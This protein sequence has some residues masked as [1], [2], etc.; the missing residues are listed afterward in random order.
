MRKLLGSTIVML[1]AFPSAMAHE[2][3]PSR[4]HPIDVLHSRLTVHVYKSGMFSAFAH[5][6]EIE[7][8]IESGEVNESGDLSV[9]LS[10]DARKLL[11]LDPE[12]SRG[13]RAE[14]QAAMLGPQV[15]DANRFPEI[16]FK[17]TAIRAL[18][19]NHWTVEGN[20]DLHGERHPLTVD[21]ALEDGKYRG[22]AAVMQT[23]FGIPP[24]RIAG[25][26]VRV[27]DQLRIDFEI[28][29]GS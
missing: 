27:K 16:R 25:G 8:P 15:L 23:A 18:Q 7:A 17:S 4:E 20:L 26:T 29:V 10:V 5:N 6:H 21:V 19:S 1:M 2:R 13:T 14:I 9:E 3:L 11:V 28:L 12:A 24:V 22:T